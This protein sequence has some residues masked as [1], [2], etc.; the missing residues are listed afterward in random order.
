[1]P[2]R[3]AFIHTNTFPLPMQVT[4]KLKTAGDHSAFI[5]Q[6]CG[7]DSMCTCVS[8]VCVHLDLFMSDS[9]CSQHAA[10]SGLSCSRN[11]GYLLKN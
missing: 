3:R 9:H 10:L 11:S 6:C 5:S 7:D 2:I 8:S 4:V 1:M